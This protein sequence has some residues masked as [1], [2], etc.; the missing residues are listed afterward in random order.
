MEIAPVV[1]R[2]AQA[3]SLRRVLGVADLAG[4]KSAPAQAPAAFVVPLGEQ[5][6]APA[7]VLPARQ[8]IT[9]RFGVLLYLFAARPRADD[10]DAGLAA[11]RRE[12]R[13]LLAGWAPAA[14]AGAVRYAGGRL[15]AA[16]AGAIWWQDE[17][18]Y[19]TWTQ[20]GP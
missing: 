16:E 15:V 5:A 6:D 3:A 2:L 17:F 19:D 12:V 4:A 10:W 13:A 1:Q 18:S 8:R 11:V 9:H 20:G 14:D 7:D